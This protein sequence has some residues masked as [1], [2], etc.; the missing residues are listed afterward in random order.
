MPTLYPRVKSPP[1]SAIPILAQL[2]LPTTILTHRG[3][4]GLATA[5]WTFG[6][7]GPKSEVADLMSG[8]TSRTPPI[9]TI[10][11][12]PPTAPCPSA[13]SRVIMA[14]HVHLVLKLD[15]PSEAEYQH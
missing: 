3:I 10:S 11:S 7:I 13:S 2:Y 15:M 12:T 6:W 1:M 8:F 9:R 4:Q 5:C 14:I